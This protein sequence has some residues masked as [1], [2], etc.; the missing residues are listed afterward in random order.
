MHPEWIE[1]RAFFVLDSYH[2]NPLIC[3]IISNSILILTKYYYCNKYPLMIDV[4]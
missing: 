4:W 2:L 1:I 3:N